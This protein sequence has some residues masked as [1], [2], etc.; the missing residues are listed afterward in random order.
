MFYFL[1]IVIITIMSY[2]PFVLT[3][4]ENIERILVVEEAYTWK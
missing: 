2:L 1:I 4:N 3:K